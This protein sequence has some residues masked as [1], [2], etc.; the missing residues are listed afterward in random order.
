ML[1]MDFILMNK[2]PLLILYTQAFLHNSEYKSCISCNLMHNLS[3]LDFK[4]GEIATTL[5]AK[6]VGTN[7]EEDNLES[8]SKDSLTH[9]ES[10]SD[11]EGIDRQSHHEFGYVL[12]V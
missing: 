6:F 3:Y 12:I 8:L 5:T 10:S 4:G 1:S 11:N 9:S 2:V 7:D